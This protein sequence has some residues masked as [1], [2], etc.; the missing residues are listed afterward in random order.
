MNLESLRNRLAGRRD[1]IRRMPVVV[2]A[3]GSS[4]EREISLIS[5]QAVAAALNS[6]GFHAELLQVARDNL[7]LES[8]VSAGNDAERL[9]SVAPSSRAPVPQTEARQ[10]IISRVR[11]AGL[12]VTTMHGTQGEDGVW[13]GVFELLGVPYVSAGVKGSA[14][15]MDKL[16]SK[17]LFEQLG[18][19]TPRYWVDKPELSCRSAVPAEIEELVAK[20]V[21]EGSSVGIAFVNNDDAGWDTIATLVQ[22]HGRMLVEQRIHGRE[23]TAGV[24]GHEDEAVALPLVEITP[25]QREFYDYTAK[26]TKGETKYNCPADLPES[27]ALAIQQQA[28]T[29]YREFELSPYARIDC[30]L[31]VGGDAWFLEANTLPG[32]TPLSLLPLAA[33]A[34]GVDFTELVELVMLVALERHERRTGGGH[35]G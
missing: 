5:G 15:A 18:I 31:D 6:A 35:A 22:R 10:N 21:A 32:F 3:G 29:I 20:P 7:T 12:V 16:I 17:R 33:Q 19:L 11:R 25:R 30:L 24:I 9:S 4:N 34:A 13:Q 26:Y 14:L 27:L 2:V 28:L 23:L 1:A 8:P